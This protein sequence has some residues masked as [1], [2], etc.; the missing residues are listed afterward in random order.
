M[1]LVMS[2]DEIVLVE[3]WSMV[4]VFK[5]G[6]EIF[7]LYVKYIFVFFVSCDMIYDFII[8]IWKFGYF[9]FQSFFNGVCLEELG[10]DCIEKVDVENVFVVGSQSIF[11][12]D[13]ESV[14]G[15]DDDDDV[16]DEDEE[17]EDS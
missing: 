12:F 14:D 17:E 10:G 11:G 5:N 8:K 2:F 15:D 3:K 16:Y 7:I 4:L 6:L 13:D 9:Y 1:M